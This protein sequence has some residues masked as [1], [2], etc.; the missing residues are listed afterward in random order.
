MRILIADDE[1]LVRFSVRSI[2]E[3]IWQSGMAG[4]D[5][6]IHE[7]ASGSELVSKVSS[8]R[9][10]L[11]FADIRMPGMSGLEAIETCATEHPDIKWIILTGYS[12]FEYARKAIK[13]HVLDYLLKPVGP[14]EV[15]LSLR[16][17]IEGLTADRIIR[18]S[19]FE[20][21]MLS[22]TS[23]LSS[24]E[25]DPYFLDQ[26]FFSGFL[27]EIN[28]RD[29]DKDLRMRR[30]VVAE[31]S[32]R[33]SNGF[34][35]F[36]AAFISLEDG[37]SAVILRNR[38]NDR[39]IDS[40]MKFIS[41]NFTGL[42]S[43]PAGMY[44]HVED[45]ITELITKSEQLDFDPDS[46]IEKEELSKME[47]SLLVRR[48]AEYAETHF[49]TPIGVAQAADYL[50]VTPNY[51]SSVFKRDRGVSF[52]NFITD[53]RMLKAPELL[54]RPGTTVKEAAYDLGYQSSRH[55]A[56]I[57]REHHGCSPSDFIKRI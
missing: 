50:G 6:I 16:K 12:E 5:L 46:G 39:I 9:P 34:Q 48:A 42:I 47:H 21:K 25:F 32:A 28:F 31:L 52:T 44:S 43:Y 19:I 3:E 30:N 36:S 10:H 4:G 51:L 41:D 22:I 26:V 38:S 7:A 18:N 45:L 27:I 2:L 23:N 53:L 55:F 49:T 24:P 13:L 54:K 37:R 20:R 56:R 40:E 15:N 17:A 35:D 33:W 14:E 11:V 1:K 8:F 29:E 57:F